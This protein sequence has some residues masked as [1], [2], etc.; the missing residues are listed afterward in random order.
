MRVQLRMVVALVL[1]FTLAF[2]GA[3]CSDGNGEDTG[4]ATTET[5]AV[6]ETT[7]ETEAADSGETVTLEV[8]AAWS[9]NNTMNDALSML[10][11]TVEQKSNGRLK[12]EW[13]GGPESIPAFQQADA[14]RNGIVDI[15]WTAHTYNVSQIPVLEGAKFSQLSPSEEREVGAAD[16]YDRVYQENMNARYLGKGTP[17]LTFSLYTT[18][19]VETIDD[20]QGKSVRVTPAYKAF[21]EALGAA[22]VTTDPSEVYTALER[23]T[24]EGYGWPSVGTIDFGW[25]EVTDYVIDP[26]FYQVDVVALVNAEKWDELPADLQDVLKESMMEV[27]V[28]AYDHFKSLIEEDRAAL[29]ERGVEEM[30]LSSEQADEFLQ[31]AYEVGWEQV[32]QNEPE[33]GAELKEMISE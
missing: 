8:V 14:L 21:V 27:E 9:E 6:D 22:P 24:V 11:E 13:G 30:K 19:P 29:A 3:A 12:I 1:V 32:L 20:F 26:S 23:G 7:A 25:D 31:L 15:A 5:T 18:F 28:Q 4:D 10:Q 33:L 2:I 17:G 16:F